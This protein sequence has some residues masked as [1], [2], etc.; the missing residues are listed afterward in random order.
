MR[1][2]ALSF[3]VLVLVA[4]CAHY[5]DNPELSHY[6]AQAGYRY[7]NLQPGPKNSDSLFVIL[8]FSGGGTRAAA[9]SYGVLEQLR[10][11]R[12]TWEG[13]QRRLLDE[14]DVISSVSGGSF[15]AAYY[16][17]FRDRTFS[18]FPRDFLYR[19]IEGDLKGLLVNPANWVKLASPNYGRIDLAADF[20]N[21]EIFAGKRFSDLLQQDQRPYLMVNA[22]DM[23][24]GAQFTFVQESFD[25]LCSD[26]AG[27]SVARAVAASS[28]FPVAF[29]PLTVNNYPNKCRYQSPPWVANAMQDT[30]I[31]PP[32]RARAL[33][34]DS[35]IDEHRKDGQEVK[36]RPYLH[37]LDGGVADNIGLRGPLRA[38][39]SNDPQWSI[40][41][42]INNGTIKK[43]VVI[44]VDARSQPDVSYDQKSSPPG[45]FTVLSTIATVPLDNYSQD[46][47]E[48]L[49]S[50]FAN[51]R[52][53]RASWEACGTLLKRNQC[54]TQKMPGSGPADIGVY[55]VYVG[56]SR[57]KNPAERHRL[58]NY[59]TSFVLTKDQVDTLRTVGA[60]LLE[61]SP[62]FK[63]LIQG[64]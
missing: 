6:D 34:H 60:E 28:N 42:K 27:V 17:L 25:L 26:L 3:A 51:R 4:G 5:P 32:R 35:Y 11:T 50:A 10:K 31:N 40:L 53:A 37:L 55:D 9:L 41:N 22:T 33:L 57:I 1:R 19:D 58:F 62:D 61:S 63:Q 46:T 48:L 59:P 49:R 2:L 23:S 15:T 47:I 52:Q 7:G 14:V 16:T 45:T 29:T 64:L 43:L 20:Y 21:R 8:T 24:A 54:A 44:T 18:Q 30:D 38:I 56:F 13:Q 36:Q 39:L 12:I